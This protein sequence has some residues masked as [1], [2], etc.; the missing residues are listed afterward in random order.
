MRNQ[1]TTQ[2][3]E[4][5][6]DAD[7]LARFLKKSR[8]FD[9]TRLASAQNEAAE[10]EKALVAATGGR[11]SENAVAEAVGAA[12]VFQ[13]HNLFTI[14][15][16]ASDAL[17]VEGEPMEDVSGLKEQIKDLQRRWDAG[18]IPDNSQ[19]CVSRYGSARTR[20]DSQGVGTSRSTHHRTHKPRRAQQETR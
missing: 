5:L 2:I 1:I 14:Q 12:M 7:E 4:G 8:S 10:A 11:I 3:S 17:V 9:A 15:V 16:N 13:Q 6:M 18:T 19:T 20:F